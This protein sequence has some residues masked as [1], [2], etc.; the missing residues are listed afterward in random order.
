MFLNFSPFQT[1]CSMDFTWNK[2]TGILS[3]R[4]AT[5]PVFQY[6][7]T[8]TPINL[9]VTE[10]GAP[11]LAPGGFTL[12]FT[13]RNPQDF[14]GPP[15]AQTDAFTASHPFGLYVGEL[16]LATEEMQSFVSGNTAQR[17]ALVQATLDLGGDTVSSVAIPCIIQNYSANPDSTPPTPL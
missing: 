9:T 15:L 6:A 3:Y 10:Y 7:N 5:P 16:S 11:Y 2:A 8:A 14:E 17:E 1:Q 4:I 13:I 12:Y